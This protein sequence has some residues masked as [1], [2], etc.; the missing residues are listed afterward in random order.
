MFIIQDLG[1]TVSHQDLIKYWREGLKED[2]K[3]REGEEPRRK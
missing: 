1:K 3:R 2:R